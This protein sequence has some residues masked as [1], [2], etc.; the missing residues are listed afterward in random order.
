M[1]NFSGSFSKLDNFRS[2]NS[3]IS[4]IE[5]KQKQQNAVKHDISNQSQN[6]QQ[7]WGKSS[8]VLFDKSSINRMKKELEKIESKNYIIKDQSV[9]EPR[10]VTV[11]KEE[12][13][14]VDKF[15]RIK[16]TE[17]NY[18]TKT[19]AEIGKIIFIKMVN[20]SKGG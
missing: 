11:N 17:K 16:I 4:T 2:N 8:F 7:K 14:S 15:P 3:N 20:S 12:Y 6:S 10:I 18:Q 9:M 1:F 5:S 19:Q 13:D